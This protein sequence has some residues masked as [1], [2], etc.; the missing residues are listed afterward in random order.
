[1]RGSRIMAS[2]P[3]APNPRPPMERSELSRRCSDGG[4]VGM[5]VLSACQRWR[6]A[7]GFCLLLRFL[8]SKCF[9]H[10]HWNNIKHTNTPGFMCWFW[11]SLT[12]IPS[13]IHYLRFCRSMSYRIN[14]FC[15]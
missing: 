14:Y 11:E 7:S 4:G 3:A 15:R 6:A 10:F 9:L 5:V 13:L 8:H 2:E 1:M 12:L